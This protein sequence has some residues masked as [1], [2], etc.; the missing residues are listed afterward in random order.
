MTFKLGV[1][2]SKTFLPS[3]KIKVY[4]V[5]WKPCIPHCLYSKYD[6]IV[7][8]L[9]VSFYKFSSKCMDPRHFGFILFSL[10]LICI[11]EYLLFF[12]KCIIIIFNLVCCVCWMCVDLDVNIQ[13]SH[14]NQQNFMPFEL[15]GCYSSS[16][17]YT[18][19]FMKLVLEEKNLHAMLN[20]TVH[21]AT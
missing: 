3:C 11:C 20:H 16:T 6:D 9:N 10:P 21:R 14:P 18:Q 1:Y 13:N 8:F 4:G 12:F 19:C 17:E 7:L 2:C 5:N 15:E